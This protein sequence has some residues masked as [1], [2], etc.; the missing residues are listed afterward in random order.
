MELKDAIIEIGL[1]KEEIRQLND[2]K[3]TIYLPPE[4][5]D[6]LQQLINYKTRQLLDT[7]K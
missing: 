2:E 3:R 1:L 7:I 4:E 6:R 5:R